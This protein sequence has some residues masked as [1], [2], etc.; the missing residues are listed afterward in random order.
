MI[1]AVGLMLAEIPPLAHSTYVSTPTLGLDLDLQNG[2][3][4]AD[5]S[6][7]SAGTN[8]IDFTRLSFSNRRAVEEN[9]GQTSRTP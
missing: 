3:S 9:N 4:L 6:S 2:H 7:R 5:G 1:A 8:S